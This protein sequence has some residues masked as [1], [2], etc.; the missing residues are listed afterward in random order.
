MKALVYTRPRRL[1]L[2]DL[3]QPSLKPEE[4]L[5]RV[6]AVGVCGS[7]LDGFLGKSKKRIPP[8]VLG[9]EFSGEV[10]ETG[11]DVSRFARGEAAAVYPLI[12]CAQCRYCATHRQNLC[13]KRQVYGLDFHGAMA[14]YVAVPESC[15]FRVP[16]SLSY[17]EAALVEPL[18]NA[19]HV[20]RK[21]SVIRDQTGLVYGVGPIGL[22]IFLV[23]RRFGA[24]QLAVVDVNPNR[25]SVL[26][27]LGADLVVDASQTD[28]LPGILDW[29]QGNGVDFA[30][31]AVG[32]STSRQ[33]CLSASAPGG[34]IVWIGLSELGCELEALSVVTREVDIRGSY[35][36]SQDDFAEA[37]ALLEKKT[38]PVAS[39]LFETGLEQGQV[40]FEDLAGQH[41]KIMKAVFI[42]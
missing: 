25:L 34:T 3:P 15:L 7:D 4:V 33:N 23:A 17:V 26:R 29:T 18:A 13:P 41:T 19:I 8:L 11:R 38:L 42:S 10:T 27:S 6:R 37:M 30:I 35:A 28:P 31:D 40:V 24:R 39:S 21:C 36:Y 32:C 12:G 14:E 1:E 20:V 5:L 16:A 2:L 22:M 9:H